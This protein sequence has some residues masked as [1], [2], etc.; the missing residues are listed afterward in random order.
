MSIKGVDGSLGAYQAQLR[1]NQAG[2]QRAAATGDART[3]AA[4]ANQGQAAGDTVN[5]SFDGVLRTAA[6][7]TAM[8]TGDVRREKIEAVRESLDNGTYTIDNHK[9][10]TKLV[11]DE[12][13]IFG[14]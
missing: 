1:T 3:P 11:Q 10:A 14:K 9:I 12:R 8:N 4:A 13:A 6:L 5:V 7:T 2:A